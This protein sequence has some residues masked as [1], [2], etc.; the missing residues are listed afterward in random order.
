[1]KT[2]SARINYAD[3]G[4]SFRFHVSR[5]CLLQ[6]LVLRNSEYFRLFTAIWTSLQRQQISA[7]SL[8][9]PLVCDFDVFFLFFYRSHSHAI[10]SHF[11]FVVFL[12]AR[13][14]KYHVLIIPPPPLSLSPPTS[15]YVLINFIFN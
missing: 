5:F 13:T 1:M 15:H 11:Y 10:H 7:I 9:T 14:M 6:P 4:F 8:T 12:C 2:E 3:T